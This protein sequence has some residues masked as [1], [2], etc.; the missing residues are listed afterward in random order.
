[1]NKI[2]EFNK[3]VKGKNRQNELSLK[4]DAAATNINKYEIVIYDTQDID[5]SKFDGLKEDN[6]I[7]PTY[8]ANYD[9]EF[10]KGHTIIEPNKA[11]KAFT[12]T[13]EITE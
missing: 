8:L 5:N 7:I 9:P 10:W 11:I 3:V 12:A 6:T 4:F 1:M 2:I 13:E